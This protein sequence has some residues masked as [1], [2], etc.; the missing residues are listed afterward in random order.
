MPAP[1]FFVVGATGCQGG[2][3]ARQLLAKGYA[4]HAITRA[5]DSPAAIELKSMGT[6][7]FVGE[8]DDEQV[9]QSGLQGCTG[10][11]LNVPVNPLTAVEYTK[12]IL[13]AA[14][15][16][17]SINHI[18]CSTA[19]GTDNPEKL[20]AWNPDGGLLAMVIKPKIVMEDLVRNSGFEYWTILRPGNFMANFLQPK[21]SI[22]YPGLEIKGVFRTSF[23]KT[24]PIP[25]ID[26]D[27]IAKF[28]VAAFLEPARFHQQAIELASELLTVDQIMDDL[29]QAS[30]KKI[31]AY[32]LS[33]AEYESEAANN[34]PASWHKG[35]RDIAQFVD[36]EK[37]KSWGIPLNTFKQFLKR[38]RNVVESTFKEVPESEK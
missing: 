14:K 33:D 2:A 15:T 21:V 6:K 19:Y 37:V 31:S 12:H 1:A 3:V 23:E 8:L 9:L 35:L 18:I 29:S 24:T 36:M 32:Y 16:T 20:A 38:E 5:A 30:G 11:F 25:M 17:D 10:L 4:V 13:S 34:S 7:L 22:A 27:D 26:Q 28:A